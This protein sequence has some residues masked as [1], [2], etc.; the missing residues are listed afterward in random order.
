MSL[1]AAVLL[2]TLAAFALWYAVRWYVVER[3]REHAG[4]APNALRL[5]IGFG[6]NFFDT[7]GIGSFAPTTALFK[8][9]RVVPDELIPGTLNVGQCLPT[10]LQGLIFIAAVAVDPLT[11]VSMI[12]AAVI[13]ARWGAA[14]VTRLPRRAIQ[15]GMGGALLIAAALFVLSNLELIPGGGE[16]LSLQGAKIA[17]AVAVNFVLGALMTLGVGLYAPCLILVCLLGMNP[18]AAFPIMMGSCAFL[19]PVAGMKFIA[20]G[21]YDLRAS[22]GLLMGGLPAVLVAAFVVK[23]LPLFWLRWLVVVVIVYTSISMLRSAA[24]HDRVHEGGAGL[25][26]AEP[27]D[28]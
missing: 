28:R 27:R 24:A 3:R 23:Q 17:I 15:M 7:L 14:I 10:L 1:T 11:L 8:L 21:R 6:T 25:P 16:A 19:M 12:A 20:R 13:G 5:G 9:L 4:V 2:C 18:I 26:A 22:L